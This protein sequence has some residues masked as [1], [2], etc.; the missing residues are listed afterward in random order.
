MENLEIKLKALE[1]LI[2]RL[3]TDRFPEIFTK[4]K[5]IK[6]G[7]EV[8]SDFV[9]FHYN[10]YLTPETLKN[11]E[12]TEWSTFEYYFDFLTNGKNFHEYLT[13]AP[14]IIL[15]PTRFHY[16]YILMKNY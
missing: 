3:L 14:K 2:N 4:I 9:A 8:Y 10:V 6:M 13:S 12:H 15:G 7:N 1:K 16:N 11:F 5:V